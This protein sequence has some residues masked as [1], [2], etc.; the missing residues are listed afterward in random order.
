MNKINYDKEMQKEI[1][2]F[3]GAKPKLLL[4]ACCAPCAS[5]SI[6]RVADSFDL[7][8]YFY[9][10]NIDGES[11]FIKRAEELQRLCK[12]F[13]VKCIIEGYNP[14]DFYDIVKG[15]E[16]D[17]EG[18]SRC[19]RCFKLR[20][21]KTAQKAKEC[22]FDYFATTLTLSPLKNAELINKIGI[23]LA[24]D[25]SVKYLPTDFKKR[26]GYLQSIQLSNEY[27]LYRQNYCGCEFS[28]NKTPT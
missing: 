9:N 26:G 8:L 15:Y 6:L 28:K 20:L 10:P 3:N 11:E 16:G 2:S 1:D 12:T 19:A 14:Q 7:T 13:N 18:G 21:N 17:L 5:S 24:K 25:S 23:E 27:G 4:H 22:G